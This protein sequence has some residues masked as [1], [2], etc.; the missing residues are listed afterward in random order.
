MAL[1]IVVAVMPLGRWPFRAG[2]TVEVAMAPIRDRNALL[3]DDGQR[4]RDIEVPMPVLRAVLKAAQGV[5]A[6]VPARE[7]EPFLPE[8]GTGSSLR[9]IFDPQVELRMQDDPERSRLPV[10]FYDLGDQHSTRLRDLLGGVP[11]GSRAYFLTV[12]P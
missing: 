11:D 2:P 7:V 9:L 12:R 3:A 5:S 4:F 8:G 10:R 1:V 6:S